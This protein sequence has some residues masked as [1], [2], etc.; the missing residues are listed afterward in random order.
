LPAGGRPCP[1][2]QTPTGRLE[3]ECRGHIRRAERG[4]RA[5]G[6]FDDHEARLGPQLAVAD[7]LEFLRVGGE[8][9]EIE[10]I[11]GP[12][13]RLVW[14]DQRESGTPDRAVDALRAQQSYGPASFQELIAPTLRDG[15]SAT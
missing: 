9:V 11:D 5:F 12:A 4:G 7:R 6:P 14:L 3:F 13:R 15:S 8:P 10:V 1:K 2:D